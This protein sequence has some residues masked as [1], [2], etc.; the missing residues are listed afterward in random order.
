VRVRSPLISTAPLPT[1][2]GS[3]QETPWNK[4]VC[5]DS[6]NASGD[7]RLVAPLSLRPSSP[8]VSLSISTFLNLLHYIASHNPA[9]ALLPRQHHGRSLPFVLLFRKY[10][11]ESSCQ[12]SF[13]G[14]PR[15]EVAGAGSEWDDRCGEAVCWDLEGEEN[16][17][18]FTP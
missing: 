3:K 6:H 9:A 14:V 18:Q 4:I 11:E 15:G 10:R 2:H 13:E 7:R 5:V 1:D 12:S 17:T 8:P 16:Y